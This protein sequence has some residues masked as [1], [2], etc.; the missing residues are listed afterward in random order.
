[1]KKILFAV[2]VSL[3]ENG[4]LVA[5]DP[6][7]TLVLDMDAGPF[8]KVSDAHQAFGTRVSEKLR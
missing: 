5:P 2:F 8:T 3:A 4:W 1:M 6:P 7:Q